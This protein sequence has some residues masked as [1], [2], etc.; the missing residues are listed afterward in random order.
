MQKILLHVCCWPDASI[1]IL[2]LKQEGF[3]VIAFWY[4][5]NIQPKSE[6]DKRLEAFL[7]ICEIEGIR[8]IV[9]PYD[10]DRFF[11]EIRGLEHT[12]ERWEKCTKCYDMRLEL[13]A[14]VAAEQGCNIYTSSLNTS[15]KKDLEKIFK[16][17]DHAG[18]KYNISFLKR[19]FRKNNG[20]NRSVEYT[21][22]H[23]IYRQ[24][25]CGCIYS[26]KDGGDSLLEKVRLARE[27]LRER[28]KTPQV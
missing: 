24:K 9:W 16:L 22:Q 10:T 2:D 17:W 25:Y 18:E 1:P 7:K 23:D 11:R 26:I 13:S 8:C 6:H 28:P 3:E 5:P 27:A 4:D 12:P 15:P 14:Q 20:F 19:A 21:T